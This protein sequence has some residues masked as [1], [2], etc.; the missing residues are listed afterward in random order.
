MKVNDNTFYVFDSGSAEGPFIKAFFEESPL[1]KLPNG[2]C[3]LYFRDK[4]LKIAIRERQF[5]GIMWADPWTCLIQDTVLDLFQNAGLTGFE[6]LPVD[7]RYLFPT[8]KP[9]P[10]VWQL[11]V[12]GWGGVARLDSGIHRVPDPEDLGRL[13]YSNCTNQEMLID[14]TQ[15]DGSDFFTVWPLPAYWWITPRVV[16][17]FQDYGLKK[18]ALTPLGHLRFTPPTA[19]SPGFAPGGLRYFLP[20]SLAHEIGDPLGIY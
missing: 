13:I 20:D 19:L 3:H 18:Y 14:R 1:K 9:I 17:L 6:V 15:W 8:P 5:T 16:H 12:T 7:A 4:P 10:K 2:R 11:N